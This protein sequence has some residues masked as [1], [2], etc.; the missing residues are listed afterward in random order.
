MRLL[1]A[2]CIALCALLSSAPAV[3]IPRFQYTRMITCFNAYG[4]ATDDQGHERFA[5]VADLKRL[6]LTPGT[7]RSYNLAHENPGLRVFVETYRGRSGRPRCSCLEGGPAP[8]VWIPVSGTATVELTTVERRGYSN[9]L[10]V[11]RAIVDQLIVVGPTGQ[12][13]AASRQVF[14]QGDLEWQGP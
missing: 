2:F 13:V 4:E 7:V 8:D 6:Q 10:S 1:A 5:F 12:R 11:E 14:I 9:S 3:A